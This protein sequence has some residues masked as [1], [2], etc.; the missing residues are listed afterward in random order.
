MQTDDFRNGSRALRVALIAAA[1]DGDGVTFLEVLQE[2]PLE[3]IQLDFESAQQ[4]LAENSRFF[5]IYP[6][7]CSDH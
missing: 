6:R 5:V 3:V 1:D 4:I 2:F 7:C